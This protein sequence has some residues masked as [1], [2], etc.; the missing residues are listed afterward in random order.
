MRWAAIPLLAAL[1]V[2]SAPVAWGGLAPVPAL[3]EASGERFEA[4]I[5]PFGGERPGLRLYLADRDTNAPVEATA[6]TLTVPDLGLSLVASPVP[7][8]PGVREFRIGPTSSG[9]RFAALL[10]VATRDRGRDL[11]VFGGVEIPGAGPAPSG[12]FAAIARAYGPFVA[13]A[14][15]AF[16]ALGALRGRRARRGATVLV[17]AGLLGAFRAP[18]HPPEKPR[19]PPT[20]ARSA[21]GVTL[22]KEA[23]FALSI[24]TQVVALEALGGRR[25][26]P[27][28]LF[29][30]PDGKAEVIVPVAGRVVPAGDRLVRVGDRVRKGEPLVVVESALSL[31]E[32]VAGTNELLAAEVRLQ[33]AADEMKAAALERERLERPEVSASDAERRA[34]AAR[35]ERARASFEAARPAVEQL[36][37][38][39]RS[40]PGDEARVFRDVLSSA[41]DGVVTRAAVTIGERAPQGK[42]LYTVVEPSRLWA[43]AEIYEGDFAGAIAGGYLAGARATV[44]RRDAPRKVFAA[45]FVAHSHSVDPAT[46]TT[47]AVFEVENPTGELLEGMLVDLHVR[48]AGGAKGL[49]VP[50]AA[51]VDSAGTPAV[52]VHTRPTEF[53]L[54]PVVLG[55]S[56]GERVEVRSGLI[57][58][59]RVVVS[60]AG[61]L[62]AV[63][64]KAD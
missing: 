58:G 9:G 31:P 21:G 59:D 36:R 28:R 22:G 43:S 7:G 23:Q 51:V 49:A 18:A 16:L 50:E 44:S 3:S 55:S 40:A 62:R 61:A 35:F 60:G 63:L 17:A 24:R 37:A 25:T 38:S 42:V 19:T 32:R 29:A 30:R 20:G 13:I 26:F 48:G 5:V 11:I 12:R 27:A 4:E 6:A 45:R 54:R 34:A 52:F 47:S 14:S 57:A 39:L 8:A 15:L 64:S 41:V 33:G 1:V 10:A 56:D 2:A 53:E 46:A